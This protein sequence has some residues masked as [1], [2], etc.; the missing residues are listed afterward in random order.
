MSATFALKLRQRCRALG[1]GVLDVATTN[2]SYASANSYP[3]RLRV[4]DNNGGSAILLPRTLKLGMTFG[5]WGKG[6]NPNMV[7]QAQ[8]AGPRLQQDLAGHLRDRGCEPATL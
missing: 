1:D 5:Y 2:R 6:P 7:E 4:V 3:I 8:I